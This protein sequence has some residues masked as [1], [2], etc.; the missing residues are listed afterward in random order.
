MISNLRARWPAVRASLIALAMV[1]GLLD[2]CPVPSPQQTP[3]WAQSIVS[4]GDAARRWLLSPVGW[5]GANLD[6]TQRW[7]LFTGA[8]RQRFR[9]YVEGR[10]PDGTWRILFRAGDPVHAEYADLLAYRRMRGMFRP[11]GQSIRL[12][13]TAFA[14]W[15]TRRVLDDHPELDAA[16]TRLENIAIGEGSYTPSNTFAFEYVAHRGAR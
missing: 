14:A 2:G 8:S 10:L 15:M 6:F 1:V 4:R 9:L 7:S 11:R 5:I 12:Q 16:R 13:Y 3:T